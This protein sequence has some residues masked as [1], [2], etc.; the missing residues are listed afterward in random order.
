MMLQYK[1]KLFSSVVN[2]YNKSVMI[3]I[4]KRLFSTSILFIQWEIKIFVMNIVKD[5]VEQ[6]IGLT[7]LNKFTE[8][9][10]YYLQIIKHRFPRRILVLSQ[11]Q[12][13][14]F[15]FGKFRCAILF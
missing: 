6:S 8:A 3:H 7:S 12:V 4:L 9:N 15:T 2:S 5:Y 13:C 11:Q 1:H 10:H 14:V